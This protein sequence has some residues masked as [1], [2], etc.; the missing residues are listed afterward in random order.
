MLYKNVSSYLYFLWH[1]RHIWSS[2][3]YTSFLPLTLWS[4]AFRKDLLLVILAGFGYQ[5]A[6]SL[7][8][9]QSSF[10]K[11]A[12]SLSAL[13]KALA[14][15]MWRPSLPLLNREPTT[16]GSSPIDKQRFE[17]H[18]PRFEILFLLNAHIISR[19]R[20]G[21]WFMGPTVCFVCF[22]RERMPTGFCMKKPSSLAKQEA[23]ASGVWQRYPD[24]AKS[25]LLKPEDLQNYSLVWN[26]VTRLTM[27]SVR[28]ACYT[29][30]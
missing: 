14:P 18:K 7:I 17:C 28:T 29:H 23:S 8:F 16:N 21:V 30:A 3:F 6:C 11:H 20:L 13:A 19:L 10:L 9:D 24:K 25:Q 26:S 15:L 1:A 4:T 5:L 27:T 22:S 2:S 12:N